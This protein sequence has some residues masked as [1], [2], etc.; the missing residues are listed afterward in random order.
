MSND[1]INRTCLIFSTRAFCH[2][3][4]FFSL[5]LQKSQQLGWRYPSPLRNNVSEGLLHKVGWITSKEMV[6]EINDKI[7]ENNLT[8]HFYCSEYFLAYLSY[9]TGCGR[10]Y[11]DKNRFDIN[12]LT[13]K[14]NQNKICQQIINTNCTMRSFHNVLA[15][16]S[17]YQTVYRYY[18]LF[19]S[20]FIT[21]C[22]SENHMCGNGISTYENNMSYSFE[23]DI[24]NYSYI[25]L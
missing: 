25:Y 15:P 1:K 4:M 12:N 17:A 16:E 9:Y 23:P 10:W 8:F 22:M 3:S 13:E 6:N 20:Y 18:S 21:Q 2:Y 19:Y 5:F 14:F 24:N 7:W 11:Y